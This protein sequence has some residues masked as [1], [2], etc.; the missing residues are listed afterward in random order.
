MQLSTFLMVLVSLFTLELIP[1]IHKAVILPFT[2]FVAYISATVA[3]L[4]DS[5][6]Q[7]DGI[8]MRSMENGTAVQIMPGCNGVEAMICLAAA[9]IAFDASW[10]H[11]LAG[12]ISGFFAI[13]V[14][15]VVR[16][17]SLFYLLQWNKDWFEWAHLYVWQAL[18]ILDALIIFILWVR[19]LPGDSPDS[20]PHDGSHEREYEA[21]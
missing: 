3:S 5:S 1:F 6:I 7:A 14:L 8:V 9:I 2:A 11:K 10:K 12:L 13:Q 15:N 20:G 21:G 19:W 16:I 17:I 4:F 18:I